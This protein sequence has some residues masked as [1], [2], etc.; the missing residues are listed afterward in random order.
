MS[1]QILDD[2]RSRR[3]FLALAARACLGVS[4]AAALPW[5]LGAGGQVDGLKAGLGAGSATGG[6]KAKSLIYLFMRGGMS[7]IDTLDPKPGRKVQGEFAAIPTATGVQLS[8]HL[9]ALARLAEHFALVRSL[10]SKEGS[11]DR[12]VYYVHTGYRPIGTI[13][14]PDVGAWLARAKGTQNETL[15]AQV[16]IGR[17]NIGAGFLGSGYQPLRVDKPDQG[18]K[19]LE[20]PRLFT[21]DEYRR[22]MKLA[23]ELDGTFRA[24]HPHAAVE[25]LSEAYLKAVRLMD[26]KD[27]EVFD[28]SKESA[29]ARE[30]YGQHPFGQGLL[31]ARRLVERGVRFVEVELNGWDTH[32]DNFERVENLSQP[33]D[34]GLA[35]LLLDLHRRGR[36][37]T[38][39]VVLAS[40]FGRSPEINPRDG[41]DH[42]PKAFSAL[43]AGGGIKGGAVYGRTDQDGREVEENPVSV[44]DL[45]ATVA[46][47][48]GVDPE[49]ELKSP[50]GR[51][52]KFGGGGKP[53]LQLF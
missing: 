49:F 25:A 35:A 38:T 16:L 28:I 32:E 33:L 11:H 46:H 8:E 30:D 42:H 45:N 23:D 2:E 39:M 34:K 22:S 18:L 24:Q 7:H 37:D 1:A 40:E 5:P 17:L 52:F 19:N 3:A 51:P 41:R 4:F 36:L 48:F 9:P 12:G 47:A 14:H 31:M 44:Q 29:K 15:P 20:K 53:V 43:L 13:A 21:E 27:A 50:E 26:S 10:T 6:G